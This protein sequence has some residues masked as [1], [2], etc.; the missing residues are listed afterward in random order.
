MKKRENEVA[1]RLIC[2][3]EMLIATKRFE[4]EGKRE[5]LKEQFESL[6]RVC[7]KS[8]QGRPFLILDW[9]EKA[10][11]GYAAE[12]CYQVDKSIDEGDV[13]TRKFQGGEAFSLRFKGSYEDTDNK[14]QKL[15][16]FSYSHGVQAGM[17][18]LEIYQ[19]GLP[20]DG[21]ENDIE[22][23]M[24]IHPWYQLL[25]SSIGDVLG[26]E[27]GQDVLG[28]LMEVTPLTD[29]E[30]RFKLMKEFLDRLDKVTDDDQRYEI[31]SR[32][33]D[34]FSK[35]RIMELRAV[36]ERNFDV[37]EVLDYLNKEQSWYSGPWREGREIHIIKVPYRKKMFEE[38]DSWDE[39][40]KYYC[41]CPIVRD[42]L[43]DGM[44]PAYCH[45]GSGWFRQIWEGILG[46]KV[47]IRK[48]ST[49]LDGGK[50]CEFA[51]LLPDDVN[52]E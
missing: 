17:N 5:E 27:V 3:D 28:E 50:G 45:C 42:R 10:S 4:Y 21:K 6:E 47:K 24:M 2:I 16:G 38:A 46:K 39:K 49:L 19:S 44:P 23:V 9:G 14:Y 26:D 18:F 15:F 22:L 7:G 32:C 1:V 41:H 36:Y 20:D 8:V 13:R 48:I 43:D 34:F 37:D 51:V 31:L 29:I 11:K 33:S 25:Y 52:V 40:R 30:T 12:A 35:E